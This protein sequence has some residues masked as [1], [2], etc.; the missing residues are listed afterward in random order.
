V[1]F[2][3]MSSFFFFAKEDLLLL[4]CLKFKLPNKVL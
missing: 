1:P 4:V 2:R 3:S